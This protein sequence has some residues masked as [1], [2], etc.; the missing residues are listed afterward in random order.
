[1]EFYQNR[2]LNWDQLLKF[3]TKKESFVD[4]RF[5]IRVAPITLKILKLFIKTP[6][7]FAA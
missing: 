1:M 4:S 3:S 2:K 6:I 7:H 5:I